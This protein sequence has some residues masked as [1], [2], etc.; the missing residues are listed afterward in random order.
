MTVMVTT[1]HLRPAQVVEVCLVIGGGMN[2]RECADQL[3]SVSFAAAGD[4]GVEAVLR[5]QGI[6]PCRVARPVKAGDT[7]LVGIGAVGGVPG[8]MGAMEVADTEV[9]DPDRRS[10]R[11][12]GQRTGKA[13]ELLGRLSQLEGL[14]RVGDHEVMHDIEGL[15]HAESVLGNQLRDEPGVQPAGHV[16]PGRNRAE[17]PGVVDE[18]GRLGEAGGLGDRGAVAADRL[19]AR[20]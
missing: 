8:L 11:R 5:S 12:V 15:V 1:A 18:A 4:Q 3:E 17:G 7:P 2:R 6:A 19:R 14:S 16:V 9:D 20:R 13:A 10:R